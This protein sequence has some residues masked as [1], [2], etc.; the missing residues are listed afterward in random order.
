[1]L[2]VVVCTENVSIK[3]AAMPLFITLLENFMRT[4]VPSPILYFVTTDGHSY[5]KGID[6][7][8]QCIAN[9]G[10]VTQALANT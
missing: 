9:N 3:I 5:K 2:V 4:V 8:E 7:I 10:E 6:W 1:M